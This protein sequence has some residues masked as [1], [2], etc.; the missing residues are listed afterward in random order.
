MNPSRGCQAL[1]GR[2]V[3]VNN[4]L[5]TEREHS[6]MDSGVGLPGLQFY[7]LFFFFSLDFTDMDHFKS[8]SRKCYNIAS[9]L[10]FGFMTKRH[11][12]S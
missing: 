9:V 11:V 4:P 10:Y 3:R 12:V 8:L 1:T 5:L 2:Q 6:I 7:F